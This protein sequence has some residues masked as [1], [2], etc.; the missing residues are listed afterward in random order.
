MGKVY[1]NGRWILPMDPPAPPAKRMKK[2]TYKPEY[3]DPTLAKKKKPVKRK[4]KPVRK[5]QA[6]KATTTTRQVAARPKKRLPRMK[7]SWW[8]FW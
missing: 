5:D 4:K 7:K 8:P 6:R 2:I 3:D 1:Q